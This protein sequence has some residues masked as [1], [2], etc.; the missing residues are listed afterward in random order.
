[1]E[2]PNTHRFG[3]PD[4]IV[5]DPVLGR[6]RE[7]EDFFDVGAYVDPTRSTRVGSGLAYFRDHYVDG[8]VATNYSVMSSVWLFF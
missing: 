8:T 2:S 1:M 5:N 4:A 7:Q 3:G 6:T